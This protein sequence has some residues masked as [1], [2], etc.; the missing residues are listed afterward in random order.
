MQTARGRHRQSH[1]FPNHCSKAPER[2]AFFHGRQNIVFPIR[3]TENDAIGM[4]AR[5][6]NGREKQIGSREAP[7][8]LALGS[9]GDS[10]NHQ[11]G[12]SPVDGIRSTARELVEST[13]DQ[14]TAWQPAIYFRNTKR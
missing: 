13:A 7:E 4:Q 14:S 10:G 12:G 5:L 11:G 9:R 2:Q 3:L 8:H 1:Q 6:G